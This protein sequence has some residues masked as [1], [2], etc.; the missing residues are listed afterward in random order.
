M[1]LVAFK[2][3]AVFT[4]GEIRAYDSCAYKDEAWFQSLGMILQPCLLQSHEIDTISP[5]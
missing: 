1:P 5:H 4:K 2:L 3:E